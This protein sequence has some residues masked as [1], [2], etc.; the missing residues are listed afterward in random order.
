MVVARSKSMKGSD[1]VV[2]SFIYLFILF[3]ICLLLLPLFVG[4]VAPGFEKKFLNGLILKV[5]LL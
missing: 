4:V 1:S 3:Y 2:H 5:F